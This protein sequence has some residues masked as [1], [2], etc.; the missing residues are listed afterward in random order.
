MLFQM[1][2]NFQIYVF[3]DPKGE[4]YDKTAG[5]FKSKGY[6]IK[7]LNLVRPQNSDGYNPLHHINNEIDVDIIANTIVKGQGEGKS[8]DPFWDDMS[9]MLLKALIYYLKSVRPKR[10][11]KFSKL[12]RTCQ[13]SKQQWWR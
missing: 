13:N 5:Y 1:H 7:V 11:T 3:T 4:L 8:S 2:F 6:E 10:R 9:E 12:F